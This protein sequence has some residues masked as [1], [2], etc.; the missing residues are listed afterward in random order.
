M[1][2]PTINPIE[3][4]YAGCRFRS[5]LEARW[6]V[7]LDSLGIQWEYEPQGHTVT[8]RLQ[9]DG[10]PDQWNYLPD[11]WLPELHLWAEVKGHLE[12]HDT[13]RLL[14]AAAHLSSNGGGGCHDNGGHD[15]VILGPI[16]RPSIGRTQ[17][18]P[19]VLHMH[20]GSLEATS[21]NTFRNLAGQ[22]ATNH[23]I[24]AASD[25]SEAF[26]D[27][28]W[29]LSGIADQEARCDITDAYRAAR[30]ARFEHGEHGA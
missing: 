26:V 19:I 29:L 4:S 14:S 21:W 18:M 22:C 20:K 23:G 28:Q 2:A 10:L 6:A 7:A 16:P 1:S 11:F 25:S 3:T 30:S 24:T 27:G 8:N 17:V 5:R 9:L 13:A 12:D 15:V